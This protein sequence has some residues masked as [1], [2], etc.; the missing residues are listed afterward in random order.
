MGAVDVVGAARLPRT[1][2][3]RLHVLVVDHDAEEVLPAELGFGS[4]MTCWRRLRDW[5]NAGVWQRLHEVLLAQLRAAGRLDLSRAAIDG[6]H[7]RALKGGPKPDGA[8]STGT[9]GLQAPRDLRRHRHPVGRDADR[10]QSQ[11]HH[12][13]HTPAA[14][15]PPIRGKRGRPRRRPVETYADRGYDYD[16]YRRQ[17]RNRGIKPVIARRGTEHGSGLGTKRWVVEQTIALLHCFRR[18]RT[19][20]E[21]RDGIHEAFLA[22][23]CSLICWRR[24]QTAL[25]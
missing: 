18:L 23:A 8:R 17:L 5:H 2:R 7:V 13:A 10:R 12:P 16:C 3:P 25:R 1:A 19:R 9:A 24:L 4:G 15:I 14:A 21:T 22:L 11:R 6:S 20:W